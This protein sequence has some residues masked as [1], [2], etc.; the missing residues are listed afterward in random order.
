MYSGK[1][2]FFALAEELKHHLPFFMSATQY[3]QVLRLNFLM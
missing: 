3:L 1:V 2:L